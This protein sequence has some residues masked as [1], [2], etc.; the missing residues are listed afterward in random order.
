ML[1]VELRSPTRSTGQSVF[2]GMCLPSSTCA[3]GAMNT[4]EYA[5]NENRTPGSSRVTNNPVFAAGN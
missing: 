2:L 1:A 5:Q 4:S 3:V